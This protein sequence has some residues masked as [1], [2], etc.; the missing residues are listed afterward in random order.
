MFKWLA[1]TAATAIALPLGLLFVA[2]A[3]PAIGSAAGIYA[4][5]PSALA[6]ADIPASYLAWYMNAA[7]TCPG[8]PWA[9]LA[10]IGKAES[11]HGR[12]HASGVHSGANAAGAEGPMQFLSA[13]FAEYA[14][15]GDHD[16]RLDI[17]D[18]ADAIFTAAALLR[19]TARKYAEQRFTTACPFLSWIAAHGRHPA[20]LAQSDLDTWHTT[21]RIHQ[22]PR[23]SRS[24]PLSAC[25][26]A[27]SPP[28][29]SGCSAASACTQAPTSTPTPRPP[30]TAPAWPPPAGS[31]SPAEGHAR[32]EQAVAIATVIVSPLQDARAREGIGR[33]HLLDGRR[34]EGAAALREAL[35]IYQRIG[36]PNA[37]RVETTPRDHG[38]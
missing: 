29:S 10:G 2:A 31:A 4:G 32:H 16:G 11:D 1:V 28:T 38:L 3:V 30:W 25:P 36:S 18:P 9:V 23:T 37:Q 35:A 7:Q 24:P 8:L 27:T 19:P 33:C 5:G 6:L 20:A 14:V 13:T 21:H 26:T 12:S 34:G 22:R 15:D 17:Y